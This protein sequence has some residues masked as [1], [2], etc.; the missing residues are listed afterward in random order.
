MKNSLIILTLNEIEGVRAVFDKIPLAGID[1]LLVVDGGSTDGTIDFF[2]NR[3]IKVLIQEKKGRA[4]A[5]RIGAQAAQGENLL[6]FSPDGN[7][8]PGDIVKLFDLLNSSDM[9]IASRFL[10][11]AHNEEDGKLLPLRAWANKAFSL[12]ANI[13]WNRK[14][15]I[16]DTINGFR[17]I[18]KAAFE[19]LNIDATGFVIEYQMS[20]RAMKSGLEVREIPTY[21]GDRIGGSSK[22]KSL[23]TGWL[24]LKFFMRELFI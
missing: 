10:R 12:M 9:A 15:Y 5:F 11:D 1:E 19:K 21:E 23:P 18:K 7:E 22:A 14:V 17:A 4:E 20:I 24:F 13:A 3:D 8:N 16:T 2:K 6:F